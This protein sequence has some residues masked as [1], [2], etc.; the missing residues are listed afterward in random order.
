MYHKGYYIPDILR[1]L[2]NYKTKVLKTRT[3]KCGKD[4]NK[5]EPEERYLY[6]LKWDGDQT[7]SESGG[8]IQKSQILFLTYKTDR[9][10]LNDHILC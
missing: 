7:H 10:G 8:Q 2:K 5:H 1:I 4:M 3:E 9:H 6:L